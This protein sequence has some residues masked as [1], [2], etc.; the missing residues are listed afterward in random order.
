MRLRTAL[1][2]VWLAGP[3]QAHAFKSGSNLYGQLLEGIG[4]VFADPRLIL[5]P[6][7]LAVLA[8]LKDARGFPRQWVFLLVGVLA[9]Q[10]IAPV[11]PPAI[12][13]AALVTAVITAISALSLYHRLLDLMAL[14]VGVVTAA[15]ALEG[16]GFFEV[17]VLL[18]IGIFVGVSI[19]VA[20]PAALAGMSMAQFPY[21]ITPILW[22]IAA[23]WC[24]AIA[25]MLIAFTFKR[26]S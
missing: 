26:L 15:A 17:P 10:L 12:M 22:R 13:I 20:A 8:A 16:H 2:L 1:L 21:A 11:I 9:G 25:I 7:A 14:L 4:L 18:R 6:L 5:A 19:T 23:S 24:A 3:A